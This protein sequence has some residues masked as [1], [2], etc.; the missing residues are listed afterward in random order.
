[1]KTQIP[2]LIALIATFGV[3]SCKSQSAGLASDASVASSTMTVPSGIV[4]DPSDHD[5]EDD[6]QPVY[7]IDNQPPMPIAQA[8]CDAVQEKQRL[9]REACCPAFGAFAPTAECIRTLSAALRLG[10]VVLDEADLKA[11]ADA[12]ATAIEGCDWVGSTGAGS[13]PAACSGIIRGTLKIGAKCRSNLECLEGL[14][15]HGLGATHAGKCGV[16]DDLHACNISTDSLAAFTA[17]IDFD[18]QHPE[19]SGRCL[20]GRCVEATGIGAVCTTSSECGLKAW[21]IAGRCSKG[22]LPDVGKACTDLC[23]AG[24]RCVKGVCTTT[25]SEGE[26]CQQ[27]SEC[28][29]HCEHG[30]AGQGGRCARLCPSFPA[31][32]SNGARMKG[33]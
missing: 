20:K 21:C 30:D 23:T 33:R 8:Y 19:C 14:R 26:S 27:D 11:C 10:A 2:R 24:R 29:V 3:G 6:V 22:P 17:Q 28:R 16:A 7:P 25:K 5:P 12:A 32:T 1:M 4:P 31:P 18:R 15:C 9:R 13:T